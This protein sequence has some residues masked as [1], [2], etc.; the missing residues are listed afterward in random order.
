MWIFALPFFVVICL[1]L[2]CKNLLR[3]VRLFFFD[4]FHEAKLF[5]SQ[6][7]DE[8]FPSRFKRRREEWLAIPGQGKRG[9]RL[10]RESLQP[11][12]DNV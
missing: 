12:S 1:W 3:H 7:L 9:K 11:D 2:M 8:M 6:I 4:T 10:H 5:Y